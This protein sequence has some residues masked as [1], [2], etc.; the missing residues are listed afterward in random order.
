[1]ATLKDLEAQ[2][3]QLTERVAYLESLSPVVAQQRA[4][5]EKRA[6]KQK[7][8]TLDL[9]GYLTLDSTARGVWC[10]LQSDE[11]LTELLRG[12]DREVRDDVLG[13]LPWQR[14]ATLTF[15][16]TPTKNLPKLV[17]VRANAGF[18]MHFNRGR[19]PHGARTFTARKGEVLVFG[20][21]EWAEMCEAE[22]R[23]LEY[24][25]DGSLGPVRALTEAE[26]REHE[27]R[28]YLAACHALAGAQNGTKAPGLP[29]LD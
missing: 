24:V 20:K 6:L 19:G 23:L 2:L 18:A 17:E 4:L 14:Q 3:A 26:T 28:K 13:R 12:A 27:L 5:A 25:A 1:M 9:G 15:A 21:N 7:L 11:R 10:G 8:A 16:L 22:P 29:S